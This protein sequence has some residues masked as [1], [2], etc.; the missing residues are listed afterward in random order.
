MPRDRS[1]FASVTSLSFDYPGAKVIIACRDITKGERAA[2]SIK[3]STGQ[4]VIVKTLDLAS[5]SSVKRFAK[6]I[7]ESEKRIDILINNAGVC[8]LVV[9]SQMMALV[10]EGQESKVARLNLQV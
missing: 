4:E 5:L 3:K 1:T 9:F 8:K 10:C 7:L 6:H 2:E